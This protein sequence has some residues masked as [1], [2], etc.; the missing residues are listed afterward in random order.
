M[1]DGAPKRNAR[2]TLTPSECVC[3]YWMVG[4]LLLFFAKRFCESTDRARIPKCVD[5]GKEDTFAGRR[6][7]RR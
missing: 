2:V 5:G 4:H 1:A 6:F 3:V 7:E